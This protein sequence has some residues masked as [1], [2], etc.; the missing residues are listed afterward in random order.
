MG[1][2]V[3]GAT[4]GGGELRWL[5]LVAIGCRGSEAARKYNLIQTVRISATVGN[6]AGTGGE[7]VEGVRAMMGSFQLTAG[8]ACAAPSLDY[9]YE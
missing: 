2:A 1:G 6:G 5:E 7:I 8:T 4:S 9:T 3:A